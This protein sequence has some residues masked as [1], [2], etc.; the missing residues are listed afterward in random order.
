MLI[1]VYTEERVRAGAS[2][3]MREWRTPVECIVFN[4]LTPLTFILQ[5]GLL[6]RDLLSEGGRDLLSMVVLLT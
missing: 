1:V 3:G 6:H 2:V 5:G 4:C